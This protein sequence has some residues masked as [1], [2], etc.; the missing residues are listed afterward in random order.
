MLEDIAARL[1]E[2]V[3]AVD[4][5]KATLGALAEIFSCNEMNRY[6]FNETGTI[7]TRHHFEK[8]MGNALALGAGRVAEKTKSARHCIQYA[9]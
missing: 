4:Y 9:S 8:A 7:I 5:D 3:E 2:E 6:V 1:S